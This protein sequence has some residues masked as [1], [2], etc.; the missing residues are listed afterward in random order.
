MREVFSTL[1]DSILHPPHLDVPHGMCMMVVH[2]V[3]CHSAWPSTFSI[4]IF[5][6]PIIYRAILYH[7]IMRWHDMRHFKQ[8]DEECGSTRVDDNSHMAWGRTPWHTMT[9]TMVTWHAMVKVYC[10]SCRP[11]YQTTW[12]FCIRPCLN[13]PHVMLHYHGMVCNSHVWFFIHFVNH[14][15]HSSC[16]NVSHVISKYHSHISYHGILWRGMTCGSMLLCG[17]L[18]YWGC[19][20]W[21]FFFFVFVVP[22][23]PLCLVHFFL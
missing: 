1:S 5:I 6:R 15:L 3:P 9:W 23:S 19:I 13:V 20:K 8:A 4:A 17:H 2:V 12:T 16:L 14:I 22:P 10:L 21:F 18:L 11:L 7:G